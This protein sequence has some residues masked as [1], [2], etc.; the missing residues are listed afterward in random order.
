MHEILARVPPDG[1]VL[2]LGSREGSFDRAAYPFRTVRVDLD[3]AS[4][5][6]VQADAAHLPFPSHCFDAVVSNH[7]LEHFADLDR[8]LSEIGRVLARPG[9]LFIAVPDASTFTDRLYRW[10]A[11]GGGHLN[12][13]TSARVWQCRWCGAVGI[14]HEASVSRSLD[15]VSNGSDSP[16]GT[17]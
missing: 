13:F 12:A 16:P 9:A 4:G 7:S 17:A 8:A 10:L 6:D 2:D 1:Y 11:K 5:S 14:P 15:C 3:H